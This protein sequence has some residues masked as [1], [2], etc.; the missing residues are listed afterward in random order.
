MITELRESLAAELVEMPG[1]VWAHQPDDINA[2][3]CY[4][5]GRPTIEGDSNLLTVSLP[6]SVIGSRL[7]DEDSQAQLDRALDV[8]FDRL[9]RSEFAIVHVDPTA[10]V[11]ADKTYPAYLVTVQCGLNLC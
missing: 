11:V 10:Q 8:V 3:P 4:V 9:R 7:S 1:E 6:V 2:V 5:I